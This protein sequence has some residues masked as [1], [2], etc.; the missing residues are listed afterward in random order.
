MSGFA[1][2]VSA[3]NVRA[4]NVLALPIRDQRVDVGDVVDFFIIVGQ[5]NAEGRGDSALSPAA[6]HGIYV[7]SSGDITPLAD[8]VGGALTGS[9]WP[10]FSNE[11]YALT[12]RKSAFIE[13]ATGGTALIPDQAG[14][15]W[16][17][18][19]TL[20][21]TTVTAA[22][23]AI[24]AVIASADYA[25][26]NVCFLWCQGESEAQ[27]INGTTITGAIYKQALIDLAAYFK[28]AIPRMVTMGVIQTGRYSTNGQAAA[29]AA[30]RAA[31]DEACAESSLLTMLYRGAASAV[32]MGQMADTVHWTQAVLN[33]AGKAA[34]RELVNG[35]TAIPAAPA[36]AATQLAPTP[37]TT[38]AASRTVSHTTAVGT[39]FIVVAV[40]STRLA[41][42]TTFT[43]TGVTFGGVAMREA[44]EHNV[45]NG[46]PLCRINV[47]IY[48]IDEAMFGAPLAGVTGDVV[49][50]SSNTA[51]VSD[52]AIIDCT[53]DG[54]PDSYATANTATAQS[55]TTLITTNADALIIT[56]AACVSSTITIPTATVTGATE[57][58]DHGLATTKGGAFCVAYKQQSGAV[59]DDSCTVAWSTGCSGVN[60]LSV[61]FRGKIAGE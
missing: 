7:N 8:P 16:S 57:I 31:Q 23:T 45:A 20:R 59:V 2:N 27:A 22:T 28:A 29:W 21:A 26:G 35:P 44:R 14:S 43:I 5:S 47:A 18:S 37:D 13:R 12:G 42:N 48:Y 15:N 25:L 38:A 4:G 40:H 49:I 50:T 6:P 10:T 3:S 56:A 51:N 39:D 9:M 61:A 1:S 24:N 11:W 55:L 33:A 53:G 32:V 17:P 30:I 54:Y 52:F 60:Q 58:M 46:S 36:I 41:A 19:G 34:A